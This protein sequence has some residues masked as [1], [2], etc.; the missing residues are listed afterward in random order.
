MLLGV[1]QRFGGIFP[2]AAL[3]S[4]TTALCGLGTKV[5]QSSQM[6]LPA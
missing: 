4:Q 5:S 2:L 3:Q 6:G 1:C